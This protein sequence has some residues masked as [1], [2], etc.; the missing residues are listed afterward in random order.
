M[1]IKLLFLLAL[2]AL[3]VASVTGNLHQWRNAKAD[4]QRIALLEQAPPVAGS[5][6]VAREV[7]ADGLEHV[8]TRP[9]PAKTTQQKAAAVG[10][11]YLDT[12]ARALQ[13]AVQ[14]VAELTKVNAQMVAT[15]IKLQAQV[16]AGGVATS[17]QVYRDKWLSLVYDADSNSL[18]SL[19][20]DVT[21]NSTKYWKR[22]W[23]LAPKRY[24]RDWYSDDP[25]VRINNVATYTEPAP[26]PKRFGIGFQAGYGYPLQIPRQPNEPLL[27]LPTGYVGFGFSYNLKSF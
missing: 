17:K 21:L 18:D 20:Y 10:G 4:A 3:L 15:N 19:L 23:F 8:T 7:K 1:R 16:N 13:V 24:Y 5:A 12:V 25:R 27:G 14:Q 11:A 6:I 2:V 9:V 22:S 26:R